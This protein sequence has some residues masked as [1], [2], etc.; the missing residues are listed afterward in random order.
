[1]N[2]IKFRQQSSFLL[3][4][5][6]A[7][8]FVTGCK[9]DKETENEVI[10]KVVVH[11]T[12][13]NTAFDQEFEAVDP[14]GDG[15]FNSIDAIVLPVGETYHCRLHVYDETKNPVT[16]ITEEIQAENTAHLFVYGTTVNAL[17]FLHLNTDDNG[18][19]FG[20]ECNWVAALAGTGNVRIALH[21]EPTDKTASDPGGEI[22][23]D[24]TF[25]VTV[26]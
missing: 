20:L 17:L 5:L 15:V 18:E 12:G 21:H 13:T 1:M 8:L 9:K 3:L 4:A 7:I 26:Q 23:F 22:D 16:D 11:L 6:T 14:D 10:T 19:P 2:N 25:P 24:V